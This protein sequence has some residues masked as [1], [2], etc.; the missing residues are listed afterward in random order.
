M[1]R[2]REGEIHLWRFDAPEGA[3]RAACEHYIEGRFAMAR[4]PLGKP[5]VLGHALELGISHTEGVTLVA[6]S[7]RAVGLDIE[8]MRPLPD[9]EVLAG[10]ALGPGEA[11]ELEGLDDSERAA[12]F[13]RFWVRKEALLKARGCGLTVDPREV[14]TT[15]GA[16]GWQWLDAMLDQEIAVSVAT[17]E[18]S[19]RLCW[20]TSG[21]M[22]AGS[23]SA[24]R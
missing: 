16:P 21:T 12:R 14:D 18:P 3:A 4:S 20:R 8:R 24:L 5:Y 19:P 13:Y 1:I 22:L 11:R 6:V 9:L 2:V 7:R 17:A 23:R 10:A 15:R